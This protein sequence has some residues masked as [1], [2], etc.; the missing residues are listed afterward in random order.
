MI[1]DEFALITFSLSLLY[2]SV[3][4]QDCAAGEKQAQEDKTWDVLQKYLLSPVPKLFSL[5]LMTFSLRSRQTG[6]HETAQK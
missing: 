5:T 1:S 2:H 3:C 4:V 6:F